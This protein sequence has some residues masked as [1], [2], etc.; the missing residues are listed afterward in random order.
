MHS[1]CSPGKA[2]V[3][4]ASGHGLVATVTYTGGEGGPEAKKTV[5]VPKS[6]QFRAPLI[7]FIVFLRNIF[8]MWAGEWVGQA[9]EPRVPFRPPAEGASVDSKP[10]RGPSVTAET[11]EG[12]APPRP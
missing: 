1:S 9:E 7:H 4:A 10:H 5:C 3:Y 2:W 12:T 11:H 6:P 8:L